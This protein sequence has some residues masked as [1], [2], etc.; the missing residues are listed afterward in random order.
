[1][2]GSIERA[3]DRPRAWRWLI[4]AAT[5][6]SAVIAILVA[7]HTTAD[8]APAGPHHMSGASVAEGLPVVMDLPAGATAA[9]HAAL[10]CGSVCAPDGELSGVECL[11]LLVAL[12]FFVLF[13]RSMTSLIAARI[14]SGPRRPSIPRPFA[15]SLLLF[16]SVSRT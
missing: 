2:S 12:V 3:L 8:V 5:V 7:L 9:H 16:I 11:L 13:L 4:F 14:A 10:D 15:S 6:L 1:M